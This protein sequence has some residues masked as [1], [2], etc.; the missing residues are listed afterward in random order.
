M[1]SFNCFLT[2]G[3]PPLQAP[4]LCAAATFVPA[5]KPV[6][7]IGEQQSLTNMFQDGIAWINNH[8]VWKQTALK[9]IWEKHFDQT[10]LDFR[11][12]LWREIN[13]LTRFVEGKAREL[14]VTKSLWQPMLITWSRLC[15]NFRF[16]RA[17]KC[18]M[19]MSES[20]SWANRLYLVC[21]PL[22]PC[23][24]YSTN[25]GCGINFILIWQK[26]QQQDFNIDFMTGWCET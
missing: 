21:Q 9:H 6:W 24:S 11:G 18:H 20:L 22:E 3:K 10:G 15:W 2:V 13:G 12:L 8:I 16:S 4:L 17:W 19:F 1:A 5:R 25:E 7:T 23:I 14:T 26:Q